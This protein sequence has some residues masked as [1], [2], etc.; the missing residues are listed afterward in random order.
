MEVHTAALLQLV[1][2]VVKLTRKEAIRNS[3]QIKMRTSF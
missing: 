3:A 1:Q 2:A